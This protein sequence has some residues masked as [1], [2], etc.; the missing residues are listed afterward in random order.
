MNRINP[1]PPRGF[2][3]EEFIARLEM[4]Q[5]LMRQTEIDALLLT[6]AEDI[7]YFSG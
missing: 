3:K 1:A 7:R 6:A 5:K 4:A 2:P